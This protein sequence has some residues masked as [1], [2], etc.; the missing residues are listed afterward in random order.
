MDPSSTRGF[1]GSFMSVGW[2]FGLVSYYLCLRSAK[3]LFNTHDKLSWG[4][5]Y[6]VF[7]VLKKILKFQS[8]F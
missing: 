8:Q 1:L 3:M 6:K 5:F 2:S 4:Q 7:P